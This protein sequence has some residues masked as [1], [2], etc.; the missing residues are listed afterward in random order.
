MPWTSMM[1][2]MQMPM[3]MHMQSAVAGHAPPSGASPQAAS[4]P[5]PVDKALVRAEVIKAAAEVTG[6]TMSADAEAKTF[7]ESGFDSLAMIELR[8]ALQGSE[9]LGS[10][11]GGKL[12][13]SST[14]LFDYP[15]PEALV[16]HIVS[17]LTSMQASASA[18]SVSSSARRCPMRKHEKRRPNAIS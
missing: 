4:A 8:N 15:T 12:K 6:D 3:P 1:P 2:T 11:G 7:K 17:K 16:E 13:L 9:E 18:S 5:K 10:F 14:A